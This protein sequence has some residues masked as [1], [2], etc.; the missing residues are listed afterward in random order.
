MSDLS[1]R[2]AALSPEQRE[3]LLRRL[4]EQSAI[5]SQ[6][7]DVTATIAEPQPRI[8]PVSGNRAPL[9]F[10]QQRLWFIDQLEPNNPFY[11]VPRDL[12]IRGALDIHALEYSLNEV[13]R[14][15]AVL[16][17]TFSLI[18]GQPMQVI[19]PE[20]RL[21]LPVIDLREVPDPE[22]QVSIE[23][24]TKQEAWRPFNLQRGPL[25]RATLLRI[26]EAEYILSLSTHHIVSDRWSVGIMVHEVATI[27]QAFVRGEQAQLPELPIQYADYSVW[28]REWLQGAVLDQQLGYWKQQLAGAPGVLQLPTDYPRPAVQTFRGAYHTTTIPTDLH[29]AL[30]GVS[31]REGA[32]LFMTLL[33]A[34]KVLLSRYSGQQDIVVGAP[35][36]G[37][38]QVEVEGL[39]GLFF[40]TLVLR[41]DLGGRPTFRDLLARVRDV[42]L[43]AYEHQDVPFEKLVEELRPERNLGHTPIFQ[44]LFDLRNTP[45]SQEELPGIVID[46]L[47][48]SMD[49]TNFDLAVGV[50]ETPDGLVCT[51]H[52]STDL[53]AAATIE[54]LA[55]HFQMLLTGIAANPEQPITL[56]PLLTADEHHELVVT[57]N[58]T[59]APYPSDRC[60]HQLVQD[61]VARTPEAV[62]A[63]FGDQQLTYAQLNDRANQLAH[64]LQALGVG[65][66]VRVGVCLDRSLALVV[67]I[68]AIWKAGGAFVP[69]DPA[70]PPERSAFILADAQVV[71]LLTH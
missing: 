55:E 16:R 33:A 46:A 2:L 24:I 40:N 27:Y 31:R 23:R 51:F 39:I 30:L 3:L 19:A 32:T 48:V 53:F 64:A 17:T 43:G 49:T 37:R 56:L 7:A 70:F 57:R 11:N 58:A 14:R 15:H 62:A 65:P 13:V 5:P 8:K 12:H 50:D 60:A 25:L 36:A 18:D 68:L 66:E 69:L 59:A 54:R 71:A 47:P 34:F 35:I 22:R 21:S 9:S 4:K 61:Q 63:I 28:Q 42:T 41:T 52:Y 26:D 44:V 6:G 38:Q 67:A 29:A 1:Q 20:L 10:A 45:A